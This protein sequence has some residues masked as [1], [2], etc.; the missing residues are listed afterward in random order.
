MVMVDGEFRD[1]V[2]YATYGASVILFNEE[3]FIL[4]SYPTHKPSLLITAVAADM[5]S[6]ACGFVSE[7][8]EIY[9]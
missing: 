5:P 6:F 8:E 1:L 2:F 4:I 7:L 3:L 9:R